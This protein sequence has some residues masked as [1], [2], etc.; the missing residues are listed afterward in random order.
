MHPAWSVLSDSA[1]RQVKLVYKGPYHI[2]EHGN[3][4]IRMRCTNSAST[5]VQWYHNDSRLV[6]SPGGTTTDKVIIGD[7]GFPM[8][9]YITIQ[10]PTFSSAGTYE[11]RS[12]NRVHN[13]FMATVIGK[14]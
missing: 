11:C 1:V 7:G 13:T 12:G 3:K 4:E 10:S 6:Q 9:S 14:Y 5:N 2:P 8:R